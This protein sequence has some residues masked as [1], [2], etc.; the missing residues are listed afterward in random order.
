MKKTSRKLISVIAAVLLLAVLAAAAVLA[1]RA[2]P[3]EHNPYYTISYELVR[4][5]EVVFDNYTVDESTENALRG[6]QSLKVEVRTGRH[7]G[8]IQLINNYL[9]PLHEK[10]AKEGTVLTV[11]ITEDSRET[12]YQISVVNYDYTWL[13]AWML[14]LF[15]ASVLIVGRSKGLMSLI[16][17]AVTLAALVFFLIPMWLKGYPPIPLTLGVCVFV[18]VFCFILLS[19]IT[20]K[21][22]SAILGT[23]LCVIFAGAFA[24]VCGSIAGVSGMTMEEAEW[25]LDEGKTLGIMLRV[26][27]LF[28]SGILISSLGAVM[29]VSMSI[30]SSVTELSEVNPGMS[31]ASLFKSGMNI[32]RDMIGTMTNT[33]IL[34]FAGTSLNLMIIMFAAGMQPY[35]LINNNDTI[36]EVI[37]AL[38]GSIGLVLAVPLTAAVASAKFKK[39]NA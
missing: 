35:Q 33:L 11:T 9:G 24:A 18:T 32:G 22:V 19:G 20:R 10:L 14:V 38:A 37:R 30:A 2:E 17:L 4:V 15:V 28:V 1:N 29:D 8:D 5:R 25:L 26:R 31:S 36:M 6:S 12:G 16:G 7:K 34:A 23:T 27:G 13:L 39:K 21:T 3:K